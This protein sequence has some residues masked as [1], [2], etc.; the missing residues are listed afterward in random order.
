MVKNKDKSVEMEGSKMIIKSIA[1]KNYRC[2]EDIEINFHEKLTVIV[3]DNG[4]GKTSI[5][6]GLAVS[7]GTLF[8]GLDGL[9]GV[10]INKK[11]AR[12][13]AYLMGESE[14]VQPQ[15]PVEI[16][17]VGDIDGQKITWKRSLNGEAGNTTV[18]DAKDITDIAKGYQKRMRNGDA[19]LVLPIVAYYGTG[20]LWDYHRK[21]KTDTFKNSTKTNGY[22]DSLDGTANTKLMMDWFKK[23]TIQKFQ[24]NLK[25]LTGGKELATVHDAMSMCYKSIT[26]YKD[27]SFDYNFDTD[28]IECC[29][30]NSEG[31]HMNIPLSQMSDGYKSTISLIADIA[32][33]MAVLNPQ[34]GPD[35]IGKTSGVILIDEVDLHLH[36]A[37]QHRILGD[38]QEIFPRVQFIVTTHA[39]AVISSAKSENL[40]ILKDCKM[41]EAN[42]EI[43]GNDVNSILKDIMGVSERNPAIADL[44]CQFYS[45]LNDGQY[46]EAEKI[47]D[48]ID[49]QRDYHD[50]EVAADRVKLKLER[51]RGGKK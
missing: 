3:G 19:T 13:N 44:F 31:L 21:K 27:V 41:L 51:I 22:I 40:V 42:A 50:K 39:P 45:R 8:I 4:S 47:L 5:L 37:W 20:R 6:E 2:F 49:G 28:E 26:G 30:V 15:Y 14:D 18:K 32:Y 9:D 12:L 1:L 17:A 24:K 16:T 35:V 10:S 38:L 29:Y 23:K 36:P 46:D 33:R 7:L 34:F 25:G 48:K 11:D 43:Y